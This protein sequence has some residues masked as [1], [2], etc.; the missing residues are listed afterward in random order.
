[1]V[2][3]SGKAVRELADRYRAGGLERALYDKQ[4]P[5]KARLL[6]VRARQRIIAMVSG[7][8]PAAPGALER[9]LDCR[10]S[11]EAQAGSKVRSGD[12]PDLAPRP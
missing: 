6:D 4:R 10:A 3:L 11:A 5:G 1:M 9:T 8:P 7:E 2:R 12:S